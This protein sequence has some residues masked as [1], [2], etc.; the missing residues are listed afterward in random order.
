M[1]DYYEEVFDE[2]SE[3]EKIILTAKADIADLFSAEVKKTIEDAA[4][5]KNRLE[6]L[7]QEIRIAEYRLSGLNKQ[8]KDA[9]ERAERAELYDVPAKYIGKFVR[10]ATGD[11]APGDVVWVV[12]DDGMWETCPTCNGRKKVTAQLGGKDIEVKCPECDGSGT[13]YKKRSKVVKQT[14]ESIQ[15]KLC[16]DSNRVQYWNTENIYLFGRDYSIAPKYIY[17]SEEEALAAAAK[18][19]QK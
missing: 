15:L 12:K 17:K 1:F 19:N 4:G 16:F 6:Q 9:E 18:E 10:N 2:P 8:V 7:Q 5:A 14:V 13:K 3:V 11:L